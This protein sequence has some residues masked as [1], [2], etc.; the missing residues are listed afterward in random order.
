MQREVRDTIYDPN[1]AAIYGKMWS[2]KQLVQPS[3]SARK[4]W[5]ILDLDLYQSGEHVDYYDE[6][7]S[8]T[9]SAAGLSTR[10]SPYG[11]VLLAWCASLLIMPA[12]ASFV[13]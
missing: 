5:E 12:L 8:P 2:E 13:K 7:P 9:K 3:E 10:A 1:Q 4:M 6:L 11:P